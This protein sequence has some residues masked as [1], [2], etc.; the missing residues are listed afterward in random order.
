MSVGV[1]EISL[2]VL[3]FLLVFGA[4]WLPKLMG[5]LATGIKSFKGGL[6]DAVDPPAAEPTADEPAGSAP[7]ARLAAPAVVG[8]RAEETSRR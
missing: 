3:V 2:L 4:G 6:K 5:D 7:L 1:W 8:H